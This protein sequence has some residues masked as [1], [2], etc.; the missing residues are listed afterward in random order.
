VLSEQRPREKIR[1]QTQGRAEREALLGSDFAI[2]QGQLGLAIQ[3]IL[4]S[5]SIDSF[6][7]AQQISAEDLAFV[8]DLL[9][10]HGLAADFNIGDAVGIT[11]GGGEAPNNILNRNHPAYVQR[12]D[13]V[14]SMIPQIT[15]MF[16]VSSAGQFRDVSAEVT[17]GRSANSDHYSGG[18]VDFSGSFEE[19]QRLADWAREQPFVSFVRFGDAAHLDHVHISFKIGEFGEV[20]PAGATETNVSE[21]VSPP[22]SDV[23]IE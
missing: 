1:D 9:A 15:D 11:G 2:S 20:A 18:A 16:N 7:A 19:M 10:R 4:T 6:A 13:F 14:S 17:P 23:R 21:S 3:D 5:L 8:R 12:A 22:P